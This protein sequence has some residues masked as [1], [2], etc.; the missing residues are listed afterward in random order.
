[1]KVSMVS[2][3]RLAAPPQQGQ[4]TL[5]Q[6][7]CWLKGD[8]PFPDRSMPR[9]NSTGKSSLGTGTTPQVGQWITGIGQPQYRCREINQSRSL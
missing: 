3:S 8:P 5:T 2:V 1:M 7:V 9:G 4:V 6:S